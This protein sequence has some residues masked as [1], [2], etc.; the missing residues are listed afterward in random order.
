[1]D[2]AEVRV[3]AGTAGWSTASPVTHGLDPWL[4]LVLGVSTAF[5]LSNLGWGL[6]NAN[7]SW[8]IGA[9]TPQ[10]VLELGMHRF[11]GGDLGAFAPELSLGHPLVLGI[12]Y[13]PYVGYLIASGQLGP[14]AHGVGSLALP[15]SA[16]FHLEMIGRLISVACVVGT[17]GLTYG[18]GRR[19]LGRRV[20]VLAAWFVATAYPAMYYAHTTNREA[21]LL[22][23]VTLALWAAVASVDPGA[24]HRWWVL[25]VACGMALATAEHS[26]AYVVAL[27]PVLWFG[28]R[29]VAREPVAGDRGGGLD[30][31]RSIVAALLTWGLAS[32]ALFNLAAFALRLREASIGSVGELA[33]IDAF[34]R[35]IHVPG[36]AQALQHAGTMTSGAIS[37]L[38]PLLFSVTIA[39]IVYV[40]SRRRR[41][42]LCLLLPLGLYLV[43][44]PP[45]GSARTL[46]HVLPIV[47]ILALA[48]AS[49]CISLLRSRQRGTSAAVALL[50]VLGLA[51]SLEVDALMRYD[52]RYTAEQWLRDHVASD[53]SVEVYQEE[54][55]LPRLVDV[56]VERVPFAGRTVAGVLD[57]VPDYIVVSSSG[58]R[59]IDHFEGVGE[60]MHGRTQ[61]H[62]A[63]EA[64]LMLDAL[65]AGVLPYYEAARFERRLRLVRPRIPGLAPQIRVFARA[66]TPASPPR[67]SEWK[68]GVEES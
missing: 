22:F 23:W 60:G 58:R 10:A 49:F 28:R 11:G 42:A 2:R 3:R 47:P 18:I 41:A 13:A 63:A 52:P 44:A 4:V 55:H 51:R 24:R 31:A 19:L 17:A 26:L 1:M 21:A 65:D 53:S 27:V 16:L 59:R 38:G 6:P 20:G 61:L 7:G 67:R 36:L 30:T 8:A 15:P 56:Q 39:G 66:M 29:W 54:T 33:S 64:S 14:S 25:G 37:A 43:L 45:N 9:L 5:G 62:E 40:I 12:V 50:C 46:H 32:H 68:Q 57:R 48:A 35:F 34:E